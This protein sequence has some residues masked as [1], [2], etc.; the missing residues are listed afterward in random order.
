MYLQHHACACLRKPIT[1]TGVHSTTGST[2]YGLN[3]DSLKMYLALLRTELPDLQLPPASAFVIRL[4]Y[5]SK[6]APYGRRT[7]ATT[8]RSF[9]RDERKLVWGPQAGSG[10]IGDIGELSTR[11]AISPKGHGFLHSQGPASQHAILTR[12]EYGGGLYEL[13]MRHRRQKVA[14][15][16]CRLGEDVAAPCTH[17]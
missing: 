2:A 7:H 6:A 14:I 4:S 13:V 8:R 11:F 1:R 16:C 17:Q 15:P 3:Y 12:T 5:L 9:I 10:A